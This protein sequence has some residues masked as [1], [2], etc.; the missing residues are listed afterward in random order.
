MEWR[1]GKDSA[2]CFQRHLKKK[3]IK[4]KAPYFPQLPQNGKSHLNKSCLCYLVALTSFVTSLPPYPSLLCSL[5]VCV[6]KCAVPGTWLEGRG[7]LRG[8]VP[9][10][11]PCGSQG[12]NGGPQAGWQ[13]PWPT[14][15]SNSSVPIYGLFL[16]QF[17][18]TFCFTQWKQF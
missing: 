14:E 4:V 9:I 15:S 18:L 12:L 3:K 6:C 5:C 13:V 10:R 2:A 17:S 1:G 7:Q 16:Y 11:V 8:T